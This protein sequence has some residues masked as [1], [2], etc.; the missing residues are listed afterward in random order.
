MVTAVEHHHCHGGE[1]SQSFSIDIFI[2]QYYS[3]NLI[4]FLFSEG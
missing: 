3:L 1:D 2:F 4:E